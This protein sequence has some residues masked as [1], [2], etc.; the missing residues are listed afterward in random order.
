[1]MPYLEFQ[2]SYLTSTYPNEVR[3]VTRCDG[4]NFIGAD[5]M[6]VYKNLIDR[7]ISKSSMLRIGIFRIWIFGTPL[8]DESLCHTSVLAIS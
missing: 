6:S 1:M 4:S 2:L 5:Y 3:Y 8:V 7:V